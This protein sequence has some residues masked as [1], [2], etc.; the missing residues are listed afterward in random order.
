M[1]VPP[2]RHDKKSVAAKTAAAS[3]TTITTLDVRQYDHVLIH[4]TVAVASLTGLEVQARANEDANAYAVVADAAADFTT[5]NVPIFWATGDLTTAAAGEHAF[6]VD[7][8][9]W[10]SLRLQAKSGG[11]ATVALE[12]G[13]GI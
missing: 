8:R 12:I 3:L 11:T 13:L 7:V 1:G 2:D 4:L 9:G 5:P 10:E 6:A